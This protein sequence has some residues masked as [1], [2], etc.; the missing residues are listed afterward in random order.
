MDKTP[1]V[2]DFCLELLDAKFENKKLD[3]RD[4]FIMGYLTGKNGAPNLQ[5][6]YYFGIK[7]ARIWHI[8]RKFVN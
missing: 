2:L 5:K 6:V 1:S 4:G 3:F 8:L 7:N